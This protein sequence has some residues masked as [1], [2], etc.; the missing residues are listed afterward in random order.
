MNLLDTDA[1][2]EILKKKKHGAGII[3]SVTLIEILRRIETKKRP[4][5]KQPLE[6]SFN[7]LSIDN[8]TVESYCTLYHK[9]KEE[10]A[11][12]PEADLLIAATAIAYNLPLETKNE[13]FQRL[14]PLGL[15]LK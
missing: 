3:S 5:V 14:K 12:L 6:E 11:S 8:K 10:G 15:K 1:L 9:L 2:I 13:H 7:L 4:K